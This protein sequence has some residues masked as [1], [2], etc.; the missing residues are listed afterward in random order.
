MPLCAHVS[1]SLDEFTLELALK[2][3]AVTPAEVTAAGANLPAGTDGSARGVLEALYAQGVLTARGAAGLLAVEF[4][5]ALAPDLASVRVAAETLALVPRA[6]AVR[7]LVLPLELVNGRLTVAI[8]DPVDCD[9]LEVLALCT[10]LP[11]APVIGPSIEI[12]AAIERLYGPAEPTLDQF[13]AGLTTTEPGDAGAPATPPGPVVT[14]EEA[15]TIALVHQII[16]EAIRRRASDIHLEP[17]EHRFRVR[18]RIDGVLLEFENPPKR[19][20]AAIVS[21]VKIMANISIA[22]KRLPQDGRLQVILDG[23]ALDLRVASLPTAHGESVVL[24]ILDHDG[25]CRGLAGLGLAVEEVAEFERLIALPDGLV[26]VTGPTGSGKTTTLYS[27]LHAINRPDRKIIT[28]EDPVEYQV[29]GINQVP[30]RPDVGMTFASALRALLR[31]APNVVMIG[32]I[33]DRET[34]EIAIHAALTGHLVLST[35]HTN[36]AASAVTRLMDLGARPFLVASALRAVVAQRLV[37]RVCPVCR[38]ADSANEQAGSVF[39]IAPPRVT[40]VARPPGAGCRHCN[41]TGFHGRVGLF[42]L[43]PITADLQAL[44]HEQAGPAALRA[45]ARANGRRTL[46]DDGLRKVTAGLTTV[47]E[48]VSLTTADG[49]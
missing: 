43:L 42:E 5:L 2:H 37:R 36:D 31:Q 14:D 48:V 30:V 41:G 8:A 3:G 17:L 49:N 1:A 27:L 21:R 23:R 45:R 10:G 39:G 29:S 15:P 32:E 47:A 35:L 20:Q 34:A 44:I 46:R 7:H 16:R 26:L 19:L 22:E 28:V 6:M 11:I 38:T 33:R 18:Y 25:Q 24:R 9:S 40:A 4:G 13:L 12:T